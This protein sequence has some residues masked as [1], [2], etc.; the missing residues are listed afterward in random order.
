MKK[1]EKRAEFRCA[2]Y[3]RKSTEEGLDQ[4]FNSLDAQRE[5]GEA[6]IKSQASEGWTCV[7]DRYDDGG[8]TGGNMERPALHRL[9]ADIEAGKVHCVV[10]YK[11]DRLSRS[12]LD[13]ARMMEVFERRQ[14]SF[15]SVTQQFN[16]THSMGRLTLNILLSFAQFEREL[17]SER[18]RDKIA[19]TRRRGKWAGG[20]PPLGYDATDGNRLVIN[21]SDAAQVREIFALNRQH[22]SIS[23][24][25]AEIRRRGW[26]TKRRKTRSGRI[27]GGKPWTFCDVRRVLTNVVYLGKTKYKNEVHPGQ[28]E[29]I[30]D[31]ASFDEVQ[32]QFARNKRSGGAVFRIKSGAL[33]QG[34][35]RCTVCGHAMTPTH[36]NKKGRIRY[37]YYK[38]TSVQKRGRDACPV[39]S[40][41]AG[42]IEHFVVGQLRRIAADPSLLSATIEQIRA[43]CEARQES[44]AVERKTLERERKNCRLEI[45]RQVRG[46]DSPGHDIALANMVDQQ[47]RLRRI[48]DRLREIDVDLAHWDACHID[49]TEITRRFAAFDPVW[50]SLDVVEKIRVVNLLVQRIDYDGRL[51]KLSIVFHPLHAAAP[52]AMEAS[53]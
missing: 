51:G 31:Q 6:F 18:T 40:V 52:A 16:T 17:I 5:S 9:L 34:L 27:V 25:L 49:E 39:R 44:A 24:V 48:D 43:N 28:H 7:L 11:V 50:Q 3:T 42:E 41:P 4:E 37:R 12:L 20:V 53:T 14:I 22:Q 38:C 46:L 35:L 30:I 15:V 19:A 13:F 33:L 36:S 45:Q 10:V 1:A 26:V 23:R 29:P 32:A 47:D 21:K 8:Y 2:I